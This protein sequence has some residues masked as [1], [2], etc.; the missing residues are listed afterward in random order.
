MF[1]ER[2]EVLN[3]LLIRQAYL[4]KKL[5]HG[6]RNKLGEL[7]EVHLLIEAWYQ[8]ESEKVQYQSKVEEFQSNERT[9]LSQSG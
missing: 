1:A 9:T 2:K 8:Q 5:Q 4:T 7:K 6:I 3:L